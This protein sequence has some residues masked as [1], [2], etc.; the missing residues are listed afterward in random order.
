MRPRKPV[1]D[2]TTDWDH[3]DPRWRE[4]PYPIWDEL[5]RSCPIAHTER[6]Q[7]AYLPTRYEDVRAIA[8]DTRTSR[9]AAPQAIQATAATAVHRRGDDRAGVEGARHLQRADRQIHR[10]RALRRRTAVHQ[11]HPSQGDR[12]HAGRA[13]NRQRP[14]HQVDPRDSRARYH[15]RDGADAG[16][17]RDGGIFRW[18]YRGAAQPAEGRPDK[19]IARGPDR[20]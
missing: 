9:P 1:T 13:G 8:N 15:R 6:Y 20:R 16:G 12:P 5:R 10:R 17:S 18:P 2:W 19:P 11:A 3:L 7:G 4:D 14:V